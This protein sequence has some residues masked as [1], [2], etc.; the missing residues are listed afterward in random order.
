MTNSMVQNDL[1]LR[2]LEEGAF[3]SHY[4]PKFDPD[5]E[6]IVGVEALLRWTHPSEGFQEAGS[7]MPA[8]ERSEDLQFR[9]DSWVLDDTTRLGRSWLDEGFDF[10]FLNVNIS[11]WSAG[12]KLVEIVEMSLK[13]NNFPAAHL[14][15]ECPWRMM[16][17]DG[18]DIVPTMRAL[19]ALGCHIVLDGNPLDKDCLDVIKDTPV[20]WSK[21]CIEHILEIA[22][23]EGS[24]HLKGVI[25]Q[26]HRRGVEVIAVGVES[27]MQVALA[28][29]AGCRYAQGQRFKSALPADEM[30]YLLKVIAKTKQALS[31]I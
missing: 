3:A 24:A 19:R 6:D 5:S 28:H 21:V 4:Q 8:I 18:P 17:A 13:K 7:F 10:G 27:E 25:K 29:K 31:L 12:S 11:S 23:S 9:V 20:Q 16:A 30:T 1:V 15:L 14:S 2:G 26:W 22:E